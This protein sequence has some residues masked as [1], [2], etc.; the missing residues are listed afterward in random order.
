[1]VFLA[2]IIACALVLALPLVAQAETA[3]SQA[4]KDKARALIIQGRQHLDAGEPERAL[5]LLKEAHDIMH[6]PTTALDLMRVYGDLN[7]LVEARGVGEEAERMPVLPNEPGAYREARVKIKEALE[8]LDSQIPLLDLAISGAPIDKVRVHVEGREVPTDNIDKPIRMNPGE[9]PIEVTAPNCGRFVTT[10]KAESGLDRR[11][12]VQVDLSCHEPVVSPEVEK[13]PVMVAPMPQPPQADK[14]LI[15]A[16]FASAA[17]FVGAGVGL[18]IAAKN[19]ND[20]AVEA[21]G[22]G[23]VDQAACRKTYSDQY[24]RSTTL[25]GLAI[26]AFVVSGGLVL[27]TSIYWVLNRSTS[28]TP[29]TKV[30]AMVTPGMQGVMVQGPW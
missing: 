4:D 27:T 12:K 5:P 10:Q 20:R 6:V 9:Q 3:P 7:K 17:V 26:P 8:A 18:S 25:T 15:G 24:G 11:Y 30:S 13:K 28:E 1:M 22:V 19:A 23:C 14:R 16:G 29:K 21:A 2:R